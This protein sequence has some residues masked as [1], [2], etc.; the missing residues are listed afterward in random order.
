M[1]AQT[2]KLNVAVK[3]IRFCL[4]AVICITI[5]LLFVIKDDSSGFDSVRFL[6]VGQ[7]D[8]ILITSNNHAAL[9]DTSTASQGNGIL[10]KLR[11]YG[12]N[13]LDALIITHPHSDHIGSAS[14][15][16]S[17]LDVDNII[18]SGEVPDDEECLYAYNALNEKAEEKEIP[19]YVAEK[20]M[21][22]KIG[23][24]VLTVLYSDNKAND[25]NDRSI[26]LMAK[27][28][29]IKFLLT[30][31]AQFETENSLIKNNIDLSCD[32]LK[33]AHHGSKKASSEEF[34]KSANPQYAVI[35]VGE[36]TYGHPTKEALL[37][38]INSGATV[39]RTDQMGDI[40]FQI[41]QGKLVYN[42]G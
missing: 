15:L 34:L 9:V 35:S 4:L 7:G 36:N 2:D 23:N 32:V 17:K 40:S 28:G 33:V 5:V 30:G 13:R 27:N 26:V 22:I 41:V 25:E 1:K 19:F 3:V 42:R 29:D 38:L 6:D 24:F 8:S 37:R 11:G 12:V 31:D 39:M 14:Y 16:I 10:S 18:C 20:G 21:D